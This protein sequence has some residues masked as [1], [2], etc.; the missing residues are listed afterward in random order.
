MAVWKW[1]RLFALIVDLIRF[2]QNVEHAG[3]RGGEHVCR[4][5]EMD[6][7]KSVWKGISERSREIIWNLFCFFCV[8]WVKEKLIKKKKRLEKDKWRSATQTRI[9]MELRFESVACS[10]RELWGLGDNKAFNAVLWLIA[11]VRR[12][13]AAMAECWTCA[14]M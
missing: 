1:E 6:S 14:S 9:Y 8:L 13:F 12:W 2:R 3:C 10:F 11:A 5:F 7:M 4:K